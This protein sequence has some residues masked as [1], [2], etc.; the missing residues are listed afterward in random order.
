MRLFF[1]NICFVFMVSGNITNAQFVS[2]E[3]FLLDI[4]N[5]IVWYRC[6]MGQQWDSANKVCVGSAVKLSQKQIREAITSANNQLGGSWRLP[7]LRELQS[8]VCVECDPPK[9]NQEYFQNISREAYWTGTV[10]KWNS[11]MY[12]TVNF[13]TGFSYSGFLSYQELPA[14]IVKER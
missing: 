12:W 3:Q 11:R 2:Q 1:L 9:V 6:S 8:I 10:N 14:L 13:Q 4:R 7:T 5:N